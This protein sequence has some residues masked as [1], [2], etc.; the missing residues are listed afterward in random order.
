MA[1][2][3]AL[4]LAVLTGC[5][6]DAASTPTSTTSPSS[7]PAVAES[8]P[9]GRSDA[10]APEAPPRSPEIAR[11]LPV[12]ND[13]SYPSSLYVEHDVKVA[14]R[15]SGVVHKVL[16]DRGAT[17]RAGQP[18]A[19]LETDVVS[20]EVEVAEQQLRLA[21]ADYERLR[22]LS[23]SKVVS[24]QEYQHAEIAR[25]VAKSQLELAKA[26][27]DLFT[28]EAPFEGV[29][30]ERWAVVGQRLQVDD[31]TPLFRVASREALRARVD[32]PEER[33]SGIRPG[34]RA[35]VELPGGASLEAR[36]VFVGPARDAASG[37]VPV[38]VEL[39]R[40]SPG[41]VLG[42]SATVHLEEGGERAPGTGSNRARGSR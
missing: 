32:V 34:G 27:R 22:P 21:Q 38:I 28:V 1:A 6:T 15:T 9:S 39:T 5:A 24:P 12:T 19:V 23:D 10:R 7:G 20:R 37:T 17:V 36:V 18:L 25:D 30:V 35:R 8:A 31:G 42:A 4:G 3:L 26:R 29:V 33:S 16:V 2:T 40:P 11:P 13:E 41:A 14:A